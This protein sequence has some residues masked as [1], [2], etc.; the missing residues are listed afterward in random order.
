MVDDD[1][2]LGRI[3]PTQIDDDNAPLPENVPLVLPNARY[4]NCS[5]NQQ[6]GHSNV[7]NRKKQS[8]ENVNPSLPSQSRHYK[9]TRIQL[10][11]MLFPKQFIIDV[12]LKLVNKTIKSG[13]VSYGEFLRFLGVFFMMSTIVGPAR[14]DFFKQDSAQRCDGAPFRVNDIMSRNRF[15]EMLGYQ[16]VARSCLC[17]PLGGN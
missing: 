1:E 12:I 4:E 5:Y 17:F 8:L 15:G 7:C 9:P 11:E 3:D 10:W 13:E 2:V 14:R 16:A 6:W